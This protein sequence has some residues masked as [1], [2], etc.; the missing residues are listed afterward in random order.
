MYTVI[1]EVD[2]GYNYY[3]VSA[4]TH[5]FDGAERRLLNALRLVVVQ[6]ENWRI[7]VVMELNRVNFVIIL[8]G[9]LELVLTNLVFHHVPG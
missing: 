3:E 9:L 7:I 2:C 1:Y 4:E 8:V 5:C 6:P